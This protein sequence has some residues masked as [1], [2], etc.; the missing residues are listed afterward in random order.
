MVNPMSA[1]AQITLL[2]R[3]SIGAAPPSPIRV[4]LYAMSA[5]ALQAKA[6]PRHWLSMHL[7]EPVWAACGWD[8]PMHR[9]LRREGDV[10]V[11]PAGLAGIWED[12]SPATFLLMDISPALLEDTAAEMGFDR[13]AI[14]LRPQACLRDPEI[15]RIGFAFR[16]ELE[17]G[18]PNGR[19][20]VEGLGLALAA[21]LVTRCGMRPALPRPRPTLPAARMRR[22]TEYIEAHL[23]Q[24]LALPQLAQLAGLGLSHFKTLFRRT[25][26]LPLH[27]YVIRRRVERARA[28]L[29]RGDLPISQVALEVGF[30]HQSHM[31]R[32]FRRL[33]GTS[34]SQ[35]ARR[36]D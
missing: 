1:P 5:G 35:V 3:H 15:A 21:R 18:E 10:D 22:V 14:T 4:G 8:G 20:Y 6:S 13:G 11:T 9:A 19:P 29:M 30:A 34:P 23:D 16:A 27:Q 28:L 24:D 25:A 32:H 17:S 26:G 7:G 12:E 31:A 36:G 33:L 2:R